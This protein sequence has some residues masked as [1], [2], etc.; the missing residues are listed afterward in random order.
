[1]KIAQYVYFGISSDTLVAEEIAQRVGLTPDSS[2]VRGSRNADPP[3]PRHHLWAVEC[4][5]RGMDV[6]QQTAEV[7]ERVMSRRE[8][9]RDLVKSGEAKA[10]LQI[11]RSFNAADGEEEEITEDGDLVKLSGQHQLLGWHMDG[12]TVR[13]LVDVGAEIDCDEYG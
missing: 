8:K 11:V 13:F 7:M 12:A 3:R 6:Q 9:I 10:W 1:M 5:G 2:R 4:R